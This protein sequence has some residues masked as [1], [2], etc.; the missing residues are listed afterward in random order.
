MCVCVCV[1]VCAGV[2]GL[3]TPVILLSGK[4]DGTKQSQTLLWSEK[5]ARQAADAHNDICF[6]L[7]IYTSC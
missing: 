6:V 7:N 4:K 3:E 1:C 2:Y 5:E